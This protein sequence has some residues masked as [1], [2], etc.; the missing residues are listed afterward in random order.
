MRIRRYVLSAVAWLLGFSAACAAEPGQSTLQVAEK[1]CTKGLGIADFGT[2]PGMLLLHG[3]G[4]MALVH[5]QRKEELLG[6]TIELFKKYRSKE[7]KGR[8]SFIC[9]EAG[10]TGAAMLY[11]MKLADVLAEQVDDCAQRMVQKQKRST[12]GLL[13]PHWATENQVFIDMAFPV[14]PYLLY[15]GLAFDRPEHVDL[16]VSETLE[17]FKI[18]ADNKTG[19]VHQGRGFSAADA[20]SEDNWSR[21]NGWG[22][23]ALSILVRD[24]PAQHPKRAEVVRLAKAFYAAVIKHQNQE[25]LWH[26]EMT[27]QTSYVE[28]S[29]SGL[30]LY[31]LGIMIEKGLLD[32]QYKQNIELGLRGY[33]AYIDADGSV[34]HT[35]TAGL[36]PGK[37]SKEDYKNHNW[38]LND[39]HAFGPVVLAFTQGF[40]LGI[41][42]VEPLVKT[43]CLPRDGTSLGKPRS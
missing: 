42:R 18:L 11:S 23:F 9:Y 6:R 12:E 31:G 29:G 25:G 22:A 5:P 4:E 20:I 36:C 24:L 8:G 27:D 33:L 34:S 37:G 26:Q 35:C 3:M 13:I 7:I 10:G 15:T 21:G 28:T 14:T 43:A 19:L 38:A 32:V 30:L 16:A 1:V 40:R 41:T 17:L 2:Y 39:P